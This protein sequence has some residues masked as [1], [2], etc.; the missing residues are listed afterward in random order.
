MKN[1]D[2]KIKS[3]DVVG[4]TEK[5]SDFRRNPLLMFKRKEK[6]LT[7]VTLGTGIP[8]PDIMRAG[9]SNAIIYKKNCIIVDCGRW[10]IRQIVM[11]NIDFKQIKGVIFTHLHQ[12]HINA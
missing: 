4:K 8:V 1:V 6:T 11:A 12:D 3:F 10:V 7:L 5:V 2:Q 9:P